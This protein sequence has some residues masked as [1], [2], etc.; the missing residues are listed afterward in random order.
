MPHALDDGGQVPSR[1]GAPGLL[2]SLLPAQVAVEEVDHHRGE[3]DLFPEEWAVVQTA[4]SKRQSEFAAV[5]RC[6]R[7]ALTRL[8][9]VPAP[10][11]PDARGAPRWPTGIVGSMTHCAGFAAAALARTS[12]IAA[13][14]VDSEPH[15]P[16]PEGVLESIALP[17][18]LQQINGLSQG[19]PAVHWDRLLF[20]AKESVYKVWY[21]LTGAWLDFDEALIE[22][23]PGPAQGWP[24]VF[25]ARLLVAG[26]LIGGVRVQDFAGRWTVGNGII[27]TAIAVDTPE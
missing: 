16:L 1:P 9:Q 26:P 10:I 6:A 12:D 17:K 27:A 13:I 11:V 2:A 22:L 23:R 3:L 5:R 25:H 21:P 14:G 20:C 8:G 15:A 24:G 18:E 4:V 19:Y 7:R